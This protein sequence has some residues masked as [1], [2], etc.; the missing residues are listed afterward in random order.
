VGHTS[1][2]FKLSLDGGATCVYKPRSHR[3]PLRYKGE[4]AAYRLAVALGLPNVPRATIRTFDAAKLRA[5]VAPS[6]AAN[7]F[8]REVI[9]EGKTSIGA[10]IPWIDALELVPLETEPWW[11]RWRGWLK[12]GA[13][14]PDDQRK[15]AAEISTMIAF[16][17]VTANFDR[18]SGGNVGRDKT[19]GT[20]LFV[21]NDG[22]F[23][24]VPHQAP[25]ERQLGLL[26]GVERFSKSFVKALEGLDRD[27]LREA[28][29][30]E[31]PGV[32]LLSD[33]VLTATDERRKKVL[34]EIGEDERDL[35]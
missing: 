33:K 7:L 34:A 12:K 27:K 19:T 6:G 2:V 35:E 30:E 23:Y 10:L 29:G 1:V 3:G 8:D 21:D 13:P 4:V 16:D 24:E 32:P 26:R 25:L 22:A 5:A 31:A 15:L 18:W 20:L 11:S 28:I 9:V 14:I 17:Y